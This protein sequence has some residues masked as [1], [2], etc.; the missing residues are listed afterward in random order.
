MDNI[1]RM[2]VLR[3][4]FEM[5]CQKLEKLGLTKATKKEDFSVEWKFCEVGLDSPL[6]DH[7]II[8]VT[9]S[10][11]GV[12]TGE[13]RKY[14]EMEPRSADCSHVAWT[15]TYNRGAIQV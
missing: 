9:S 11:H 10:E 13:A 2:Q 7:F 12:L 14:G 8:V 1:D 3:E 5:M 4:G 15:W 6:L